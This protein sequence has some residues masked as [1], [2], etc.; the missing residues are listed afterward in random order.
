MTPSVR[1]FTR[2]N[3]LPII[4]FLMAQPTRE[5]LKIISE[6]AV[7]VGVGLPGEYVDAADPFSELRALAK[8]AGAEVVGEL[9]QN[10]QH[11]DGRT[12]LGKGKV[13]ELKA[14]IQMLEATL[15]IFDNE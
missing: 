9:F 11:P 15:V 8:T 12:F 4:E 7:L 14:L 10:R 13:D 5:Q 1:C 3:K 6:K 2:C